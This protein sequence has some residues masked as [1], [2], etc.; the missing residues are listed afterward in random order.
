[1]KWRLGQ[2]NFLKE[3]VDKLDLR[4]SYGVN[5][6]TANK[7]GPF[8]IA[9]N[10]TPSYI[11][12]Y[13]NGLE[14][15]Y[16]KLKNLRWEKTKT[17][18]VGLD[19]SLFKKKLELSLDWY[20]KN[21]YDLF[22]D[23]EL[24]GTLGGNNGRL[25][26]N[27]ASIINDG[28]EII[29]TYHIFD[30]EDFKWDAF[31]NYRF[32]KGKVTEA[33]LDQSSIT[34]DFAGSVQN[35]KGFEPNSLMVFEFAGIDNEG[36]GLI[37]KADGT[38]VPIKDDPFLGSKFNI[39]DMKSAGSVNPKHVASFTN[40]FNYKNF[41]LSMLF[42]YQGGH[43]LLKDSYNGET[44]R[45]GVALIKKDAELA[46]QNP[47]DENFT[48]IPR[49]SSTLPYS[50][51]RGSTKNVIPGDF[52]RLRDVV[53]SYTIP[54]QFVERAGLQ[55]LTLNFRGSNLYLWTKNKEGIDPE[56]HGLATRYFKTPKTFTFGINLIF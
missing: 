34:F 4:F 6:N 22:A 43:V 53:L 55:E 56:A 13:Q 33:Y 30:R 2:E 44:L 41:G 45:D 17:S 16:Y 52:M 54:N 11:N 47:G 48:D 25:P 3:K 31:A 27:T 29:S 49:I 24:D 15:L 46:W 14:L 8:D 1:M 50:L 10:V 20:R 19:T 9:H 36:Y 42:V 39:E 26:M 5:G 7:Y 12:D 35:F 23:V 28:F 32:N 38:L 21:S 51:L 18:N 37:R 40:N